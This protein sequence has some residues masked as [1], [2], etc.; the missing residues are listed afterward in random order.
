MRGG[1]SDD[2]KAQGAPAPPGDRGRGA[3]QAGVE[4]DWVV[5]APREAHGDRLLGDGDPRRGIEKAAEELAGL[6][7]FVA[8]QGLGKEAVDAAGD[9]GEED[10]EVDLPGHR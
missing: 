7:P 4:Q 8:A 5:G 1:A 2:F 10:I 3:D 6:G 9:D